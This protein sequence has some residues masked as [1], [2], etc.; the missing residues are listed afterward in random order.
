MPLAVKR[1]DVVLHDSAVAASA[2]GRE[3]IEVVVSAVGLSFA[4]MEALL[5]E[6]LAAL[7]AEEV[8]GMPGL[9]QGCYAFL[10]QEQF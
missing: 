8:L 1:W 7:G 10:Q 9:L 6:L 3:L 4:F 2:F 5:S